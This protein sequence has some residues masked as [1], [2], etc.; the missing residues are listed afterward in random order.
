[1]NLLFNILPINI[2]PQ[3]QFNAPVSMTMTQYMMNPYTTEPIL[4]P[5]TNLSHL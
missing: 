4:N 1:M 3:I 5:Y 2:I